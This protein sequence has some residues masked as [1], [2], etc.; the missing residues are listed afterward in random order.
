MYDWPMTRKG[1]T[2]SELQLSP[3][4][5]KDWRHLFFYQPLFCFC[6]S[7]NK[8]KITWHK[9][10]LDYR[11]SSSFDIT[12]LPS[13]SSTNTMSA[14]D[15]TPSAAQD[16]CEVQTRTESQEPS[17]VCDLIDQW[18]LKDPDHTAILYESRRVSYQA[19]NDAASRIAWLLICRHVRPGDVIPVLATRTCEMVASFLGVMKTGACYVPIDVDAWGEERI[20]STLERVSARVV[21]NLGNSA[22]PGYDVISRQEVEEAFESAGLEEQNPELRLRQTMIKPTDLVYIVFTSGTTSSP[23]GV[24]IPHR[25]L[26]N[27]VQ[28]GNEEAPFNTLPR[29]EDKSLLTFSPGFDAGTGIIFST[30][31]NGAQ[32]MVAS[33][34]DFERCATQATIIAITPSMLSAIHNIQACSQIKTLIIGGE[35]PYARLIE[36][37]T[38]PGRRI[39]NGYGPTE[40]TVGSLMGRVEPSK[41]ITLGHP[42]S[43]SRVIL[44]DG[45]TE[46]DYGEICLTGPGLAVGYYQDETLTAQ[47]FVYWQ[48]ERMYRTGDFARRTY[49]GLEYAGRADSFVKNRGFLVNID[50]Q[51]IPMLLHTEVQM[52]TAFMYRDRLVAFVT[53]GNIDTR[54]LRRSLLEN[55]DAFLVPDQI[56]ALPILPLT[57]N[58]KADN[59]ALRQLLEAEVFNGKDGDEQDEGLRQQSK[60]QALKMAISEAISLPLHE[61][62][63]ELNFSELGGNSLAALKVLSYLRRRHLNLSIRALFEL[64]NLMAIIDAIQ[65]RMP[66]ENGVNHL[67]KKSHRDGKPDEE[68]LAVGPMTA[69]QTKMIQASLKTPGANT[70][71]LR[72]H[73]PHQDTKLNKADMKEAWYQILHRHPVFRTVFLLKDELQEVKPDLH[74]SWSEEETT[75]DQLNDV[76]RVR[77]LSIR[78]NMVDLNMQ[79]DTFIP[80]NVFHLV[81]IPQVKSILLFSV[82]HAQADGWSLSI[83]LNEV[84]AILLG[85]KLPLQGKPR[86]FTQIALAQREQQSNPEG[87]SFWTKALKRHSDLPKFDLPKPP[88][89]QK[90]HEWTRSTKMDL[91]FTLVELEQGA[92]FLQVNPST[93]LYAAWG[94]VLSNY[95]SSDRV[96]FGAV[97]SGRDLVDV[98]GLEGAVGPLFNTVPFLLEFQAGQ[99]V[100]HALS[101]INSQLLQ[102][103]EFQWS[104]AE[105]MTTMTGES[106][107][108]TLQTLMV[109]EYD[110]PSSENSSWAVEREDIMEFSLTLLLERSSGAELMYSSNKEDQDLQARILFNSSKYLESSIPKLL[111]HFRNALRGF[112]NPQ[113]TSISEVRSQLLDEQ[114]KQA[115]LRP[116]RAFDQ[117]TEA[118]LIIKDRTVKDA[119]ETAASNWLNTCAIEISHGNGLSY[120]KLDEESNKVARELRKRVQSASPKDVIVGVISDGS[121]YWVIA[122]LAVLKAGYICCPIDV[123]L[124]ARRIHT[125]MTESGTSVLLSATRTCADK[126]DLGEGHDLLHIVVDEF[127]RISVNAPASQLQTDTEPEDVIYLVFTSGSTGVPKGMLKNCLI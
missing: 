58:G 109:T 39:Y 90:P 91:G 89:S 125:I 78:K 40:T 56:R 75:A 28:Q 80:Y 92:R 77:S 126:V 73:I 69:L 99:K 113:D 110:L 88:P 67:S 30:L 12:L 85:S 21:V 23:K 19:L 3:A 103:L 82:H 44:L 95:T 71:L 45:D 18:A 57:P 124:P 46:S 20:V 1:D 98:Q 53:P 81:T 11:S 61:V 6:Q 34:A 111:T 123:S 33:I 27:Y 10:V 101:L 84:Q 25:A 72:I 62:S 108:A 66:I 121:P 38:A 15:A 117:E 17:S 94:L 13:P 119:F 22:F 114:E 87:V 96:A 50:S 47:K 36:K 32:L 9:R 2:A 74:L 100:A 107:S 105:V 55:H 68:E 86:Q 35:P 8:V 127:L 93:L 52:A 41:P 83:I 26:L 76:V 104:A 102:M 24:M 122:I 51:V 16:G 29:P 70:M 60:T 43:N 106:V 116:P 120:G 54:A 115:L 118:D 112:L 49:H 79:G 14:V 31:C 64:P 37:W 59:R 65:E 48:E 97:F 63:V 7:I 4:F 5:A 42:M